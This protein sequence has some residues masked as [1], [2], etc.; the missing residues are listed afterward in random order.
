MADNENNTNSNDKIKPANG[1]VQTAVMEVDTTVAISYVATVFDSVGDAKRAYQDL[2]EAQR[3]GLV[4]VLDAAYVEKTDRNRIHVHDHN[5]WKLGEGVVAGGAT[6]A[7]IGIIG[8]TILIPVALGALIGG[9]IVGLHDEGDTI[10]HR[11]LRKLGDSLPKGTSA[12]VAVVEDAYVDSVSEELSVIGGK[13]VQSG[14][15]PK[16]TTETLTNQKPSA[17]QA[18]P[19]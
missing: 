19:A 7:V 14:P 18:K 13:K 8:G 11:N 2:K 1:G 6:G 5:D 16:S 4:D 9:V 10:N 17:A 12:L 3:E 15:I